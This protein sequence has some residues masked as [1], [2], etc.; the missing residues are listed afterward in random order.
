MTRGLG[1]GRGF[2]R[3]VCRVLA[4]SVAVSLGG[5]GVY[6]SHG[7][8]TFGV[9]SLLSPLTNLV[10]LWAVSLGFY[11]VLAACGLGAVWLPPG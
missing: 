11:G 9:V 5:Y 8:L 1:K 6:G 7:R 2:G 4:S 10:S 3:R